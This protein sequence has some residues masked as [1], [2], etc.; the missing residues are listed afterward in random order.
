[1]TGSKYA[2]S[3]IYFWKTQIFRI[4]AFIE[5]GVRLSS[6]QMSKI[7]WAQELLAHC[8]NKNGRG[9]SWGSSP[10]LT[11]E[12]YSILITTKIT[13]NFAF[14]PHCQVPKISIFH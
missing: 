3:S 2:R 13:D 9:A 12:T 5:K 4:Y 11:R 8:E 6:L 7:S 14:I 1:M 10:R